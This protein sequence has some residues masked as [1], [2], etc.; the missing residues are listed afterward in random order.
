VTERSAASTTVAP[1]LKRTLN[2]WQVTASGVGIII[3]AGIYVLIGAATQEA[4]SA[5]WLAFVLAGVLSALSAL[6]YAELAGM[7]PSAGAEY[8]FAR[9][10]FN[11]FAGFITGW[12]MVIALLIAAGTVSIGFAQYARHFIDVDGRLASLALLAVMTAVIISGIQRSIWLTVTLAVLQVVGLVI[13]VASGVGHVGD[14]SLTEGATIGGVLSG[15]ALVFFAFIGF[16]EVVTLSE[17][18]KDASRVIPRALLAGLVIATALYV[19]VA[20]A[21]VS[22]VGAEA[23]ARSE[24]PLALVMEHDLGGRASDVVAAIALAATT[25][26]TL[27]ALTAASRNMY[28][29]A[30]SGS[31]PRMIARVGP[32]HAPW[33]A[34]LLGVGVAAVFAL[35][36]DIG[37][38][39]S[40]TDF[41]VYAI[42]IVVNVSVIVLRKTHPEIRRS[43][44]VP[45][46]YRGVPLLPFAA[47]ATVLVM[48]ARLE[49]AA[50]VLGGLVLVAGAATWGML[51]LVRR[52]H[53][54]T[55]AA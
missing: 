5:V 1:A 47:I 28:A 13:V 4:G 49:G 6:S 45:G 8:E 2:F 54:A 29:M 7:F 19:L 23:L 46:A 38:A 35:T 15:S 3:G 20:I 50:W 17:E 40:V 9:K 26:T 51:R 37:L 52:R 22:V 27:L 30:R 16:D 32:T 10:A 55:N 53:E 39:A 44:A 31:L 14:R 43:I 34:A 18:T 12:M 48:L 33:I 41:A 11:E 42:F 24:R 25:N 36:A 21:A